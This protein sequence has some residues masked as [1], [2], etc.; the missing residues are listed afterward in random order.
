MDTPSYYRYSP[1]TE[2]G[3]I[4]LII[5]QP[6]HDLAAPVR[7]SLISTALQVCHDDLI[8]SYTALSYVWGDASQ[9]KDILID[10]LCIDITAS[11]DLALRHIRHPMSVMRV[12]ADGICINQ[13]NEPEK[14]QEVAQMG[15]IYK[16]ATHTI[17][18]LGPA[19]ANCEALISGIAVAGGLSDNNS[20]DQLSQN[21]HSAQ[22]L[23]D[24]WKYPW[25]TR[26]W[27]LQELVLSNSPWI[28]CGLSRCKWDTLAE[29]IPWDETSDR[30]EGMKPL[31]SL[32]AQRAKYQ[33]DR[34]SKTTSADDPMEIELDATDFLSILHAR[35]A[36]GVSDPRD[37]VYANLGL[38]GP[39]LL[40]A[41]PIDYTRSYPVIFTDLARKAL[42]WIPLLD[43]LGMIEAEDKTHRVQGLPSWV[44]DWTLPVKASRSNIPWPKHSGTK[45]VPRVQPDYEEPLLYRYRLLHTESSL[46]VVDVHFF[47]EVESIIEFQPRREL[48]SVD[49]IE[50]TNNNEK[51]GPETMPTMT[52]TKD[53]IGDQEQM[54]FLYS[55]MVEKS[56][57]WLG[58]DIVINTITDHQQIFQDSILKELRG[59]VTNIQGRNGSIGCSENLVENTRGTNWEGSVAWTIYQ[60]LMRIIRYETAHIALLSNGSL[61]GIPNNIHVGEK[62]F[63]DIIA[64]R[65]S[66][67]FIDGN[68]LFARSDRTFS[69]SEQDTSALAYY[70]TK[71][72]VYRLLGRS[73]MGCVPSLRTFE[74]ETQ[75]SPD[76][77]SAIFGSEADKLILLS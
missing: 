20:T 60:Y 16:T 44:P 70:S 59:V 47:G 33:S 7:C 1:L 31:I 75:S 10:G 21:G 45:A 76:T 32:K 56:F 48:L 51:V 52:P 49:V 28:Q 42:D 19:T 57:G 66:D 4:R 12:W 35:R 37:F 5:L 65:D 64:G 29:Y 74:N 43:I 24:I 67:G 14:S 23:L 69:F 77:L 17:I 6:D 63:T 30:A 13:H 8:E 53:D 39:S 62:C 50:S 15:S 72:R 9:R 25:F 54:L 38:I 46:L 27:T 73:T 36:M 34:F 68:C 26:V 3:A 55:A 18:F 22:A 58:K 41:I 11:L 71:P 40:G 61:I 2:P